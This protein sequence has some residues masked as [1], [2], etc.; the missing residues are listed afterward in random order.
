M[1]G[2]YGEVHL[3]DWGIAKI[4]GVDDPA[5]DARVDMSHDRVQRT[6]AGFV[7]GTPGY[8]APEQARGETR[9][10][11]GR[12]DIYS[13]GAILFEALT[14]ERLHEQPTVE[15]IL[16]LDRQWRRGAARRPLARAGATAASS[17]RSCVKATALNPEQRYATARELNDDIEKLLDG[18][19]DS[20]RRA[21]IA[22]AAHGECQGRAGHGAPRRPR[23]RRP[24]P[25][26]GRRA[27]AGSGARA[28]QRRGAL[29]HGPAAA[30]ARGAPARRQPSPSCKRSTASTAPA[31]VA[32]MAG[33]SWPGSASSRWSSPWACAT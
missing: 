21:E 30:R 6:Q 8:M 25:Q 3:L 20:T 10:Y 19:R 15:N 11:G 1:L 18:D 22:A 31:P 17:T 27:A 16:L 13:L 24:A 33:P 29:H 32:P 14:L 23:R 4:I 5:A 9:T 2:D 7:V 12:S 28:Q 26:G